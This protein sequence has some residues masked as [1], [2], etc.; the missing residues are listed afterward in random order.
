MTAAVADYR[1][2]VVS[3]D[4]LKRSDEELVLRLVPNPDLLAEIGAARQGRSPMLVGFALETA[5]GDELV[6]IA[7][8]KLD[9]KKVDLVVANRAADAFE[10]DDNRAILVTHDEAEDLGAMSKRA[11]ADRILDRLRDSRRRA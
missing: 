4:K 11:L 3:E 6:A 10:G 2:A 1:P 9:D 5:K 8:A 7:R